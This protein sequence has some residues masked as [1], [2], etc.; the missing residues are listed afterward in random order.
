MANFLQP[1]TYS[2]FVCLLMM[3]GI[4]FFCSATQASPDNAQSINVEI[5]THLGDKQTFQQ[6]DVVSFLVSL[7]RDAYVL[8]IF[9]D[10]EHNLW[11]V[12]PNPHRASGHYKS[13]LFISVP[14]RNEPFEF[15]VSPPLGK[16]T[17][18]VF[19]TEKALPELPGQELDNGLK[20]LS[21]DLPA[22]LSAIRKNRT[23][24]FYGE[25]KTTLTTVEKD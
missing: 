8:I 9:E 2:H 10:A 14:D 18:W 4:S 22:I 3:I 11:Q 12:I 7:D 20:K 21:D 17:I 6:G 23:S 24:Q 15:V 16:E 25:A 5:T 13:G 19:A 1:N